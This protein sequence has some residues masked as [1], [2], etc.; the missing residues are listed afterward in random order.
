MSVPS[1]RPARF[2]A[3]ILGLSLLC[4]LVQCRLDQTSVQEE[5]F[6]TVQLNDSLSR[7]DSVQVL[8]LADGDTDRIV[9]TIWNGKLPSPQ[10]IPS[11]RLDASETRTLSIR[12]LGYTGGA[13]RMDMRISKVDGKQVV[14]DAEIPEPDT[15]KP[16]TTTP[17]TTRPDTTKP[18]PAKTSP[19]L[20]S[21]TLNPGTLSPAFDSSVKNYTAA[22]SFEQNQFK[23]T[24]VPADKDA[25]MSLSSTKL[26]SGQPSNAFFLHAGD[27]IFVLSVTTADTSARYTLKITRAKPNDSL[28]TDPPLDSI[29]DSNTVFL[30]NWK[31]FGLINLDFRQMAISTDVVLA[32]F[33]LLI[34]LTKDNFR[35]ADAAEGGKDLR[36][37]TADGKVYPYEISRWDTVKGEADI[38]VRIDTLRS[39]GSGKPIF[40]YWGNASVAAASNAAKVFPK[41]SGWS[42]VWHLEETGSG[43]AGEYKDATGQ[44]DGTGGGPAGAPSR[45]DGMAGYGQ[46]FKTTNDP[47]LITFPGEYDPGNQAW[48]LHM[49][50]K[51]EASDPGVLFSKSD[52]PVASQ[53]RFRIDAIDGS[54]QQVTL[55]RQG[56]EYATDLYL[57]KDVFKMFGFTYDGTEVRLFVDGNEW[58]TKSWTQGGMAAA[59]AILGA[60]DESG[61]NG[62]HGIIDEFWTSSVARKPA[63]MQVIFENQKPYSK[64]VT[65]VP[66]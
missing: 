50:V 29:L 65:I 18:V 52:E 51:R 14:D 21:L 31:H 56:M 9:G 59:K 5:R 66:L 20:L 57:P 44:F 38:W 12:V 46:D 33:P 53:E 45:R 15:V 30:L 1:S 40:M 11:F 41:K 13:V 2:A 23:V 26:V 17:D 61:A 4:A 36:F 49:W 27:N 8:I 63:Y 19:S 39:D 55:H 3:L 16:D 54:G 58:Q 34:R 6:V 25:K 10:N 35:L 28:T 7:F 48:T 60:G 43:H 22:L 64:F 47:S 37:A 42:G 32:D 62:F 24:A